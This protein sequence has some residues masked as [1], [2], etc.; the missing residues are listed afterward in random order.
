MNIHFYENDADALT[1]S[2]EKAIHK[3]FII[4]QSLVIVLNLN[5]YHIEK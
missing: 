1:M 3:L 2:N 5:R 4:E